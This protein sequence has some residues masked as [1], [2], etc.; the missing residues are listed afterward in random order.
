MLYIDLDNFKYVNDKYGHQVGDSLLISFASHVRALSEECNL[1]QHVYSLAA[2]L[3]GDE[4]AILI[5]APNRLSDFA[6]EFSHRLLQP[7][8]EHH[9]SPLG[10]FP[11]TASIGIATYPED[12]IDIESLLINADTAMY[13]SLIHI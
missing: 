3:S 10:R 12:G 7:I 13:L 4:F 1:N 8:Q 9:D 6:A 2:R 5:C 11:I